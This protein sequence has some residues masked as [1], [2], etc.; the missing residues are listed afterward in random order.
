MRKQ[1]GFTLIEL[2]AAIVLL[3]LIGTFATFFLSTGMRGM[4]IARQGEENAQRGQ[5]ALAR[6][7]LELRDVNGGPGTGGAPRVT[8][9]LTNAT[10][11]EYTSS[12]T[13]L[14]GSTRQLAYN[15]AN[16]VITLAPVNGGTAYTLVDG[17]S[18][19]TMST[20]GTSANSNITFTVTFRLDN[21][22]ANFSVTVKPRNT[23][24]TPTT[25]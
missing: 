22:N 24:V 4:L 17:V 16:K 13:G 12:A 20:T 25:S 8:P 14:S 21:S 19:C 6:V 9:S 5:I 15:S 1:S 7:S 3:G 2:I 11:I 10:A 18:S 23:I